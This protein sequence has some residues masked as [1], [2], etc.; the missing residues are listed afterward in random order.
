VT[1]ERDKYSDGA[2]LFYQYVDKNLGTSSPGTLPLS[3]VAV[4]RSVSPRGRTTWRNE[5]DVM[6]A[7]GQAFSGPQQLSDF[8]LSFALARAFVGSRDDGLR[9]PELLWTGDAGRVR[10]DWV[11]KASSLPRRV[12]PLRPLEPL[13]SAYILVELDRVSLNASLGVRAEWEAPVN[14]RWTIVALDAAGHTLKRYDFPYVENATQVERSI[15]DYQGADALLIVGTNLGGVSLSHPFD[16]DH[17]PCEPHG[18]TVYLAE[19]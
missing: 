19:L 14:F 4:S 11:V 2:A 17:Q 6:D 5:P 3:L 13:G 7:L 16:P 9:A 8:I 10:F 15:V 18:F 12:A 1:R